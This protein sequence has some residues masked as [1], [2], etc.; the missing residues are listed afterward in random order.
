MVVTQYDVRHTTNSVH[1]SGGVALSGI[2]DPYLAKLVPAPTVD[3]GERI[4]QATMIISEG[5][6]DNG[7]VELN[8]PWKRR[9]I[10]GFKSNGQLTKSI[11]SPAEGVIVGIYGA[12]KSVT[13]GDLT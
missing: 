2:S 9:S 12:R 8:L 11:I 10:D 4:H 13:K 7:T 6:L 5:H 1:Q 3:A